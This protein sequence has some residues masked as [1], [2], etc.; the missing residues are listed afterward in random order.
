MK[1][2][3]SLLFVPLLASMH[4]SAQQFSNNNFIYTSAPQKAVQSGNY[5]SLS[6][7]ELQQGVTYFDGL[8]RPIQSIGIGQGGNKVDINL[9]DWRNSWALGSGTVPFFAQNGQT[10]E[11][12]R[13][14][15]LNP[16]G[17]TDRLWRCV[18]DAASDADG[19]WNT[20][21]IP[22]DK[23]KP[24]R[25]AVWVKRTGAQSGTTYH[26]TQNVVNLDGSANP[27]P[28]FWT[29]NLPAL[30]TWYLMVGMIHPSTYTG[31]YSG[32]SGVYDM[33]GNKITNGVGTDFKWSGTTADS[34]FRSYLYYATDVSASQYFYNPIVQ[35]VDGTE[36]SI[37]GL[38][39]GFEASDI[40]THIEYDEFGRQTKDYLPYAFTNTGNEFLKITALA[41]TK[42]FYSSAKYE[43]TAN[44][45]SEKQI[46]ASPLNRVLQQAAPGNDW[47]ITKTPENRTIKMD[48]QSNASNEVKLY[49]VTTVW[50][51]TDLYNPTI[52]STTSYAIGQLYKTITKDENWVAADGKN[53]T[54]EEF[55]DKEGRVVLKRTYSDYTNTLGV[56]TAAG[57]VH[58]T[59]YVYDLYGNLSYVL[60]PKAGGLITA[61]VLND[62]CYQYKY[63]SRNRLAEKKLPGKDWE[64]IVYDKLD[65]P[66]LTQDANLR[67]GNKWLFTKYDAFGR[68]VYTGEYVNTA[69]TSRTAV[70]TLANASAVLFESRQGVNTINGSTAYYSNSAFPNVIDASSS[71]NLLTINYYDNYSFDLNGG[72]SET[73]YGIT[74]ITNVKS[75]ATG[76]KVRILGTSSW[77][78]NV[79][80]Y[81]AKGRPVYN[82]RKND[83]LATTDKVKSQLDFVGKTLAATSTHTRS[84]V[85][86]SIVD[87]FVY[88]HAGRLLS[89]KQKV[90]AQA[91]EIIASNTYD[92]LGQLKIKGVGGKTSQN[93]LQTVDY[94]YNVRGW[95]KDINDVGSIGSDLFAFRISY[96]AGTG[97]TPLFN[98]NISQ[99][100]WK[101]ANDPLANAPRNYS[102]AYDALNRLTVATDKTAI[103][104]NRYNESLSYD[105]NGNI[106]SLLRLGHTDVNATVF[107]TMDNL[108]YTYDAGNKLT[109][110]EDAGTTEGFKNGST[111]TTEY[112]YDSNGNMTKDLNKG[113]S[114][115]VYNH[116]NLPTKVTLSGGAIDYVYDATGAKQQ[117][118][119]SSITTDYA[120]GYQ[121][122]KI[123]TGLAELKFFPTAEGYASN[124]A[125]VFSYIYQYKDHLGNI[126]LSYGDGNNDGLVN[127][128]EIVEEN[129]YYPF[130]LI[131]KGYNGGFNIGSGSAAGQKYKYNGKELQ[132]ELGLN[133]YDY[134]ARNYDP[135]LGRWMN[136]DPLAEISRRFS[137]YTYA[138]NNPIYFIDPD[139]M[140]VINGDQAGRDEAKKNQETA[141]ANFDSKS[142]GYDKKTASKD[143]KRAYND[144]KSDLNKANKAFDRADSKYQHTQ[145][146]IDNFKTVD[147]TNFAIAD[148]LT[149]KNNAG[150]TKNLDIVVTTASASDFGGGVTKSTINSITGNID[151]NKTETTIGG[152]VSITSNVLAHEFG[153][154]ASIAT[155]PLGYQTDVANSPDHNCQDSANRNGTISKNAVDWQ[156]QYDKKYKAYMIKNPTYKP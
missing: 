77:I 11:N 124:N 39:S 131:Q 143:E 64:Y 43:N 122:E 137:P 14:N 83:Y 104:L 109:K 42:A 134:G 154:S 92:E 80:Y 138:N 147:P 28:Y 149:Y 97:I 58:D 103:S 50:N 127:T 7:A 21:S 8:G 63:D 25:Y 24:Y 100:Q 118:I 101:T 36:A 12:I 38:I 35:K 155:N 15:G 26:G 5:G 62:L 56:I 51:G 20:S 139:G 150:E 135:A 136:V 34:Y 27:N 6:K 60:P 114:A 85:T 96:N 22:V 45:F 82:Y 89:Q 152:S 17:K 90:N 65:R 128:S 19:G 71:I 48:Y 120:D 87:T 2:Y 29:G 53:K 110:V 30:N 94:A 59:Y 1:K 70:Q 107:G 76:S 18:N 111:A 52:T 119:A 31:G 9:L 140:A 98:G 126:R 106:I 49:S 141:Q 115:I 75:L 105:K 151:G 16:F 133:F 117:K 41:D 74:P 61:A 156:E 55:K 88:D 93:R 148:N 86:T 146:S 78:T 99:T 95:L 47:A 3:L 153:H 66:V 44:P 32:I 113:I 10:T 112:T 142:S 84:S 121:Y 125:G 13:I 81:D 116:L 46:E 79:I 33:S 4:I 67:A 123:S 91:E 68:P 145:N 132:D 72:A 144:A 54:T 40:V 129:N 102:Y 23:T 73:S 130:G 69:S 57:V 37:K 108:T